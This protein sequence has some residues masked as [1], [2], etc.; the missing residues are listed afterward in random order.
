MNNLITDDLA[1]VILSEDIPVTKK[2]VLATEEQ[3]KR[4]A[5]E[6]SKVELVGYGIT[7]FS[8]R[9]SLSPINNRAPNKL[10]ST[11]LTP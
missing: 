8:Q 9:D 1:I 4:F 3:M 10:T 6:K 2:A 11:L 7:D 5:R